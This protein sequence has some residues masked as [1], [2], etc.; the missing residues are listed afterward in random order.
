MEENSLVKVIQ[1]EVGM[2]EDSLVETML[3]EVGVEEDF[4][5]EAGMEEEVSP[6]EAIRVEKD[7]LVEH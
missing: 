3:V 6:V 5:V 2:V 1:V 7:S 4:R